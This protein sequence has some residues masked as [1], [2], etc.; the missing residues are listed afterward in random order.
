MNWELLVKM[1]NSI[2]SAVS[3]IGLSI[4]NIFAGRDFLE[5]ALSI[6]GDVLSVVFDVFD[7]DKNKPEKAN[8]DET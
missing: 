6:I 1:K 8:E 4:A 3:G 2:I 5:Y 7:Y